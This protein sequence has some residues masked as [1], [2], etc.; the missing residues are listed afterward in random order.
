M[1]IKCQATQVQMAIFENQC[2]VTE[3]LMA[4]T[5]AHRLRSV[6]DHSTATD[7][8]RDWFRSVRMMAVAQHAASGMSL[9][10]EY[11]GS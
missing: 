2:D 6:T 10:C 1:I 9:T 11:T 7:I 3:C 5:L 4:H 8:I